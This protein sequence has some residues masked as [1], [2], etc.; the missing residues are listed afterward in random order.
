MPES[1]SLS[2]YESVELFYLTLGMQDR[3]FDFWISATF[4]VIIACHLGSRTLTKGFSVSMAVMYTAFS[5]NMLSRWLLAQGAV[6][7]Y[8]AEMI[9]LAGAEVEGGY[10]LFGLSR[11]LTFGTLVVG[12]IITLFFI[13]VTFNNRKYIDQPQCVGIH[14]NPFLAVSGSYCDIRLN[15]F[16]RIWSNSIEVLLRGRLRGTRSIKSITQKRV[17]GLACVSPRSSIE[18]HPTDSTIDVT[19]HSSGSSVRQSFLKLLCISLVQVY[20]FSSLTY[21]VDIRSMV[22]GLAPVNHPRTNRKHIAWPFSRSNGLF[23]FSSVAVCL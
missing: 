23:V 9:A 1:G 14:E 16:C 11:S 18:Q 19:T 4:A 12:T 21:S 17:S 7:R 20:E 6:F 8:L 15:H 22:V 3:F 13:W 10:E 5:V 2:L